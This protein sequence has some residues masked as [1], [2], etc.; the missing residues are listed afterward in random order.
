MN[1]L[2]ALLNGNPGIFQLSQ[3]GMLVWLVFEV[4]NMKAWVQDIDNRVRDQ[5]RRHLQCSGF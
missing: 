1:D 4:R 5:E 3:L 2:L